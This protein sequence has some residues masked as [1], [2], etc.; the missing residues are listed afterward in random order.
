[1]NLAENLQRSA[2]AHPE[3]VAVK[4]DDFEL[5]YEA[6]ADGASRVAGW[7]RSEGVQPGDRVGV[8]CRTWR[9]CRSSTTASCGPGVRLRR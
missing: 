7:L 5:T 2:Q 6:L 3:L 9:R 4:L 8:I 1:M